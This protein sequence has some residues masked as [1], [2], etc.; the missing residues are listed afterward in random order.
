MLF[1][2]CPQA[3]LAPVR[4]DRALIPGTEA[5]P[6]DIMLPNWMGG[7]DCCL[8][9]TVVNPLQAAY[10]RMSASNQDYALRKAYERKMAELG[11]QC[12]EAGLAF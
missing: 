12:R 6:A 8:D 4:E 2:T 10:I 7:K 9:I 1:A 5:R 11:A 3:A